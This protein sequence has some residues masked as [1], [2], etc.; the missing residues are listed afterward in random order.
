MTRH[1]VAELLRA[2]GGLRSGDPAAV[3]AVVRQSLALAGLAEAPGTAPATA[4][5]PAAIRAIIEQSLAQAGLG[6]TAPGAGH[7]GPDL[8]SPRQSLGAVINSLRAGRLDLN[9]PGTRAPVPK[10][11]VPD[12][13][14]FLEGNFTS[15]AGNRRYRLYV[16]S[17][18]EA[19]LE[20]LVVM[21]HGCSQNP[22]DFAVGTGMNALAETHRLLV[23]Y[24]GQTSGDNS[25]AC[26]NW[27]RPG[28]QARG[29]G[30][31]AILAGLT[32]QIRAG[33]AIAPDR[34]FVAG[35]SAGGAMAVILG[36]TYP[37]LYAAIGVHSGLPHGSA[38][39]VPSAF[40]AMRGQG[41][42]S[43]TTPPDADRPPMIVFHGTADATVHPANA[44]QILAARTGADF[45]RTR[46]TPD[47]ARAYTRLVARDAD[48]QATVECWMIEEA[49]H[50]WS[51]G[52]PGGSYT[53]PTGP[54]ASA[55]L[56]RFFLTGDSQTDA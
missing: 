47:G 1:S 7:T 43:P 56:V 36:E 51:G 42:P 4:G 48:G 50:A 13:A 16:P 3:A 33:H 53:D 10:V 44:R 5:S 31:P 15:S 37:E 25:M 29:T 8:S 27:F 2:T 32:E 17:T 12:G 54:D 22:E 11:P 45:E 40:T 26:W 24:P 19:G 49:G 21:L 14:E 35:L 52:K 55:A 30:E 23:L 38:S 28:D 6:P 39:D 46:H 9:L 18:A 41:R 34:V 20:G